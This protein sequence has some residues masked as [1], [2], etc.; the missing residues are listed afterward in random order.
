MTNLINNAL[1]AQA[2]PTMMHES[3]YYSI[4]YAAHHVLVMYLIT[5]A[6]ARA[7]ASWP[8]VRA[9][10]IVRGYRR[11]PGWRVSSISTLKGAIG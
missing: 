9:K 3:S 10:G 4:R 1:L 11:H 7:I 2:R 5:K 6:R 8:H